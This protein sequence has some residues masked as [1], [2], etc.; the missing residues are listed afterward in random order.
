MFEDEARFG[1][2]NDP[3]RCWA[4]AGTQ[5]TMSSSPKTCAL[6]HSR[7]IALSSTQPNTSGISPPRAILR[8]PGLRHDGRCRRPARDRPRRLGSRPTSR[9]THNRLPLDHTDTFEGNLVSLG[10]PFGGAGR[11]P[12]WK[13]DNNRHLGSHC[14]RI[15][16]SVVTTTTMTR[17]RGSSAGSSTRPRAT[18]TG[19]RDQW[20]WAGGA[21]TGA[22]RCSERG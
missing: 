9:P 22:R 5:P 18:T 20:R 13:T 1:R 17:G 7:R 4:P 10:I 21:G 11:I 14:R 19:S 15:R 2:I 16:P 6:P 8:Q 3:R 12:R